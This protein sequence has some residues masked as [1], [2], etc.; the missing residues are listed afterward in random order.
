MCVWREWEGGVDWD[1]A[2]QLI[3]RKSSIEVVFLLAQPSLLGE[4]DI[5]IR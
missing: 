2:L 1:G 5:G 4:G 3:S